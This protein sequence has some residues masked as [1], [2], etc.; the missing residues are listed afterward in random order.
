M[1]NQIRTKALFFSAAVLASVAGVAAGG[2]VVVTTINDI[3]EGAVWASPSSLPGGAQQNAGAPTYIAELALDTDYEFFLLNGSDVDAA[4]QAARDLAFFANL[5]FV[6]GP[7]VQLVVTDVIVRTSPDDPYTSSDAITTL[8]EAQQVWAASEIP[9]DAVVLISGKTFDGGILGLA[10]M[11]G[12]CTDN[13]V[14]VIGQAP[15]SDPLAFTLFVHELG[16]VF[17]APHCEGPDCNIMC[18]VLGGCS[19]I[20]DSFGP[21]SIAAMLTFI[22]TNGSC[23]DRF[24]AEPCNEA[25]IAEPF[26]VLDLQDVQAF[27]SAFT[28]G[29]E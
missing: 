4:A 26:G 7:G 2:E 21:D 3:A 22:E 18:P 13:D 16:H 29:C 17:G 27:I 23:L 20:T 6:S 25:D 28:A 8:G 1:K 5:V 12:L 11:G 9:H 19:G 10:G 15:I 14:A 24:G